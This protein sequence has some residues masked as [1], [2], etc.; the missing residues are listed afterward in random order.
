MFPQTFEDIMDY[1]LHDDLIERIEKIYDI[2]PGI[3]S[4]RS[5]IRMNNAVMRE[6]WLEAFCSYRPLPYK[7][8]LQNQPLLPG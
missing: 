5:C 7:I 6:T 4:I 3:K 8:L 1:L 2:H